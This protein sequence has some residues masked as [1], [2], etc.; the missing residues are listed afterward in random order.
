MKFKGFTKGQIESVFD[1]LNLY[2]LELIHTTVLAW[3]YEH[4]E[5][6]NIL[7]EAYNDMFELKEQDQNEE[8]RTPLSNKR[9]L[10]KALLELSDNEF[11]FVDALLEL[12]P[13]DVFVHNP[14]DNMGDYEDTPSISE[15][16]ILR[17]YV[18]EAKIEREKRRIKESVPNTAN[19]FSLRYKRSF[20][21][22]RPLD[23]FNPYSF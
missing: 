14:Y 17:K 20:D 23:G 6:S 4:S 19:K 13:D 5:N 11:N 7:I 22:D 18:E 3:E 1:Q 10:T 16:D 8:Y 15:Q 2:G 9:G 12:N 21:K